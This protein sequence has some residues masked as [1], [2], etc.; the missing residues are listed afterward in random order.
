MLLVN[1]PFES[2]PD[3]VSAKPPPIP[4]LPP[5]ARFPE[6]L[7]LLIRNVP[8]K[9]P[10]P[11]PAT[12]LPFTAE[13]DRKTSFV[14]TAVPP[15]VPKAPPVEIPVPPDS[16]ELLDVKTLPLEVM[17]PEAN[18]TAPPYAAAEFG[19]WIVVVFEVKVFPLIFTSVCPK[20]APPAAVTEVALAAPVPTA[21]FDV[22]VSPLRLQST[23]P[24][25]PPPPNVAPV[26]RL[27]ANVS[28]VSVA[29]T[30]A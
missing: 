7:A 30:I 23:Q 28:F 25:A 24:T 26:A 20:S 22:N 19:P 27:F 15:I 18:T 4:W 2:S 11:P 6:T 10:A 29:D 21:A 13:L 14:E 17:T 3:V 12:P 1:V 5:L 8:L 16:V 9:Y